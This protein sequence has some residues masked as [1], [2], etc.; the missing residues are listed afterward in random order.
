MDIFLKGIQTLRYYLLHTLD[1]DW[2]ALK[3]LMEYLHLQFMMK[4]KRELYL[5]EMLW[6]LSHYFIQ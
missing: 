1:G 3:N 5:Q 2:I 6:G 4:R